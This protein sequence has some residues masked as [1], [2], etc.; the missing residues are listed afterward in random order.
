MT[1]YR[2]ERLAAWLSFLMFKRLLF[3]GIFSLKFILLDITEVLDIDYLILES[4]ELL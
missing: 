3:G 2:V 4:I 1:G